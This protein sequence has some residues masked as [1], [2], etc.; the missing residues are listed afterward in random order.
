MGKLWGGRFKNP[1]SKEV[2][3]LN[4]SFSFDQNLWEEDIIGS[5]AHLE[6]IIDAGV[7]DG[8]EYKKIK[9][10]LQ[11]I[12]GDIK[13]AG[14]Q[15]QDNYEDIHSY[16]EAKLIKIIGPVGGKLHSGRSRN[17]QVALDLHLYLKKVI[18]QI[19]E[20]IKNLQ[21]TLVNHAEQNPETIMPGYTHLQRAQPVLLAHHLLAYFWMLQRDLERLVG[22]FARTD[23]CPLGAAAVAG[24]GF[25]LN[26]EKTA[27]IL[28]FK[29]IYKNSIDA[30]SDRDFILEFMSFASLLMMHLSRLAEEIILWSSAEF[31]F[32]EIDD[33]FATGSSLM[34]QKKNPDVAELTR[35]KTGRVYGHFFALLTTMKG[36]PLA[37]NKDMQEDKEG[38]FD[39]V[40]T[41]KNVLPAFSGL[42]S[43]LVFNT[44]EMYK[45]ASSDFFW[46]TDLADLLV[47]KRIPFRKA[48]ERVGTVVKKC[49]EDGKDIY[50]WDPGDLAKF[51]PEINKEE[52]FIVQAVENSI[53]KRNLTGGTGYRAVNKQI[54]LA[55]DFLLNDTLE[56]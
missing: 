11:E 36:L 19:R 30:V 5:L 12:K 6:A 52:I 25:P 27:Q 45:A 13:K 7:I 51:F 28:G 48:H 10:G 46:A 53:A 37:Y 24:S 56:G 23:I 2:E 20:E 38:L 50:D 18:P 42:I 21:K 39:I 1:P 43:T 31:N 26:R 9:C 55:K 22:V 49:V 29:E 15:T 4:E 8:E 41:L 16:V 32:I 54:E 40:K 17:D 35:G 47:E 3:I 14:M 33:A 34:P 44:Q